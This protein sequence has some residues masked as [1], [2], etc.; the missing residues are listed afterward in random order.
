MLVGKTE[1]KRQLERPTLIWKDNIKTAV[2]E[3]GW[4]VILMSNVAEQY[5]E[6]RRDCRLQRRTPLDVFSLT[7]Q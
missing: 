2:K 6:A 3:T 4:Y 1:G 5:Q 7:S